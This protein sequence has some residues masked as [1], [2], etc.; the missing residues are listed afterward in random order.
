[1][2]IFQNIWHNQKK[3]QGD[4]SEEILPK[5][6]ENGLTK[7]E[8]VEGMVLELATIQQADNLSVSVNQKEVE[9]RYDELVELEEPVFHQK[10][11]KQYGT[12]EKLKQALYYKLV[13]NAI[14]DKI[15]ELFLENYSIREELLQVRASDYV[16]QYTAADFEENDMDKEI[17]S[18]EVVQNYYDSCLDRLQELYFKVWKYRIANESSISYNNYSGNDLLKKQ[19]FDI[20]ANKLNFKGKKYELEMFSFDEVQERF[21]DYFYLSNSII[22]NYDNIECKGIHIP[23]KDV[24]GLYMTLGADS[25]ITFKLIVSPVLALYNNFQKN[26]IRTGIENGLNKVEFIQTDMGIYYSINADMEYDKLEKLLTDSITYSDKDKNLKRENNINIVTDLEEY[27]QEVELTD[28]HIFFNSCLALESDIAYYDPNI[29]HLEKWNTEQVT[30]YLGNTFVPSYIPKDLKTCQESYTGTF[31]SEYLNNTMWW[32]VAYDNDIIIYDNFGVFYSDSFTDE[33][34]PLRRKLLIE[35]SK[36]ELPV[37]D[38]LYSFDK[39]EVS[40]VKKNELTVGVYKAPYYDG[41]SKP[42]GYIN[43]YIAEFIIDNVGYRIIS[44]NLS[45]EEFI[46]VLISMPVF[47]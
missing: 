45:Q 29:A 4:H 27:V 3:N 6:K 35:V 19:E 20:T 44:E 24:R 41:D 32:T 2:E 36:D 9:E 25:P 43:Q 39:V 7:T 1:M 34:N 15:D 14:N 21:G 5:Y 33:Y 26:G 12:E 31:M 30:A 11:I 10:A 28:G 47:E 46:K 13:Y 23:E 17:F 8:I 37:A 18:D 22:N 40:K 38:V 42:A 16:S